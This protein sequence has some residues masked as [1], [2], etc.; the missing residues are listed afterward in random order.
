VLAALIL[1]LKDLFCYFLSTP[2]LTLPSSS[3]FFTT[4]VH[5]E[6]EFTEEEATIK[7]H[8]KALEQLESSSSDK[9]EYVFY[10]LFFK[11]LLLV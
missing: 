5:H 11:F 8:S 3:P 7:Q 10:S 4:I 1:T 6:R 9:F 2:S